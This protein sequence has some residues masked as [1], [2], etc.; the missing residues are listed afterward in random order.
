WGLEYNL[1]VSEKPLAELSFYLG[2]APGF[3]DR[4]AQAEQTI[5]LVRNLLDRLNRFSGLP[6]RLRDAGVREDQLPD[7]A[8]TAIN[9]G[10]LLYNPRDV[11]YED[12]LS[13]LCKAF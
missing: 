8:R 7:I 3:L 5:S 10:A 11:S 13:L 6:L 4:R 9:D 12:A 1:D 2:G